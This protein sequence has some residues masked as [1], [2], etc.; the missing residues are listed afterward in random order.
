MLA[1][2]S[3]LGKPARAATTTRR[4]PVRRP[5]NRASAAPHVA[6]VPAAPAVPAPPMVAAPVLAAPP[7]DREATVLAA[8][9]VLVRATVSE[10]AAQTGLPNGSVGRL[11]GPT[12]ARPQASG[13]EV[14]DL[15]GPGLAGQRR[16]VQTDARSLGQATERDRCPCGSGR[17]RAGSRLAGGII[18]FPRRSRQAT[19]SDGL[20][21]V[22]G[23]RRAGSGLVHGRR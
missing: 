4:P 21:L 17:R 2:V 22:E 18:G 14:T 10:V 7:A 20:P 9:R 15:P 6:P 11:A 19:E 5:T 23:R 12:G 16:A 1:P 8:V 3:P 13:R